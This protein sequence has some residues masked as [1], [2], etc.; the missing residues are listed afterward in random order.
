MNRQQ[1]STYVRKT[2]SR[3]MSRRNAYIQGNTA[4]KLNYVPQQETRRVE[5]RRVDE[6]VRRQVQKNRQRAMQLSPA[7]IL[8]LSVAVLVTVGICGLYISLQSNINKQMSNI[9]TLESQLLELRTDNDAALKRVEASIN[10]DE[11]KAFAME[12]LGMVY[13]QKDQIVYFEVDTNDYMNQY[14]D[15]PE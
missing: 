10:L 5:E 4:R 8:F 6:R 9:A 1:G 15:I 13:P 14:Q 3:D 7:Y 11:I 12:E 2:T